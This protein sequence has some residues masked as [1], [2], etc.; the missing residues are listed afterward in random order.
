MAVKPQDPT[1]EKNGYERFLEWAAEQRP[2]TW[3][4][5][6]VGNKV[7]PVLMRAT[8]GRLRM[9]M[10]GPTVLVKHTGA[11]SGKERV[12]PLAYFTQGEEVVLI[13][14]KGGAPKHPA[15]Y[16]NLKAHPEVEA[17][18]D[19]RF[20]PYLAREATGEEREHLWQLATTLYSGF[21][22]YQRR[23]TSSTERQIPVMVLEPR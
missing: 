6:N 18:T 12:T 14:S 8:G 1:E 20:E 17:T 5:I 3:V 13:A 15:W 21:D 22:D 16:H 9:T 7:D 10:G 19:G 11:K 23:A 4:L 2:V